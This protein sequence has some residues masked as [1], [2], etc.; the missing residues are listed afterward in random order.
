MTQES[1]RSMKQVV[2]EGDITVAIRYNAR[3]NLLKWLS[4]PESFAPTAQKTAISR[5]LHIMIG[6]FATQKMAVYNCK[7]LTAPVITQNIVLN[8]AG[9]E[10]VT[11]QHFCKML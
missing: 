1:M 4:Q 2:H 5:S 9:P 11:K 7:Y 8:H 6:A 3:A 10:D